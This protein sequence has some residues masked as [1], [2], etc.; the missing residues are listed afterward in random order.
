MNW[1]AIFILIIESMLLLS[2]VTA[3]TLKGSIYD[4]SLQLEENVLVEIDTTPQQKYLAKDGA[5]SFELPT[6]KYILTVKNDQYLVTEEVEIISEKGEYLFDIFL[7]PDFKEEDELWQ[8][9]EEEIPVD[10]EEE[11]SSI[12][13]ISS[14]D[15][16]HIFLYVIAG[17]FIIFS[18][19]RFFVA[20]KKYGPLGKFRKKI[21]E[22]SMKSI[23][24]HKE[25][26]AKEPGYFDEALKIIKKHD[27]RITQKELRK[28]MLYLSEGK[29][30]LIV[31]ELEH[32]GKVEKIKKGRGNV[33]ILKE[34]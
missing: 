20:R 15:T 25:E 14:I 23:E 9:T 16:K 8:E 24:E 29:V 17:L 11:N 28:E 5:Y 31:A 27:G 33:I 22:E 26:L 2:F 34:S 30:S 19:I 6:G 4:T 18:I 3:A 7:L 21:K 10:T 32:K 1:K 12:S 13:S